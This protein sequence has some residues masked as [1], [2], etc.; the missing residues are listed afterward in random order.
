MTSLQRPPCRSNFTHLLRQLH[1]VRVVRLLQVK[2]SIN[3]SDSQPRIGGV[4]Q[5]CIRT[6]LRQL[7]STAELLQAGLE[8]QQH[9]SGGTSRLLFQLSSF[10]GIV[11][12]FPL[13][14]RLRQQCRPFCRRLRQGIQQPRQ[15]SGTILQI[16]PRI[17]QSSRYRTV[18]HIQLLILQ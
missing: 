5:V 2:H 4:L 3:S 10:L 9:T 1:A 13:F 6:S 11:S 8:T 18:Q 14:G 15:R 7:L 17:L 12:R 16:P